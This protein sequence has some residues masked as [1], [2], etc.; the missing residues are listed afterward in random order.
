MTEIELEINAEYEIELYPE[1]STI[2]ACYVGG[3]KLTHDFVYEDENGMGVIVMNKHLIEERID[4]TKRVLT[5]NQFSS[6]SVVKIP[7]NEIEKNSSLT[8]LMFGGMIR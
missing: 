3:T 7:A 4:G 2:R 5:Y 1:T 6:S 8:R